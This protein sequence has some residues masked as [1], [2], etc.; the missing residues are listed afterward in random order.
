[1]SLKAKGRACALAELRN[2]AVV[3]FAGEAAERVARSLLVEGP[4][5]AGQLAGRLGVT[6]A[7][8]RRCLIS[9]TEGGFVLAADRAPYGPAP[10]RR[11]GR[12]S[13]VYSLTALGRSALMASSDELALEAL[14]FV[15]RT[16]GDAGINAF[17]AERAKKLVSHLPIGADNQVVA[18][19][20]ALT[21]AGYAASVDSRGDH[22]VQLCQHN[23]PVLDAASEFPALC[24]AETAALGKALGR[25]V[26]RLATLAHGDGVCTTVIAPFTDRKA[27]A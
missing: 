22:A 1:M 17:A 8:I 10:E 12:P 21:E 13:S 25:H 11:R 7:G 2:N 6:A 20:D 3:K 24:D 4:A 27:T 5:T 19:A 14:R 9:L 23:C 26:T 18:I 15:H 16:Q